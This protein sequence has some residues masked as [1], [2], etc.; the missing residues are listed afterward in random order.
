MCYQ[1]SFDEAINDA[2]AASESLRGRSETT[3]QCM[4][5]SARVSSSGSI[6]DFLAE[7]ELE[8]KSISDFMLCLED[9][10][11]AASHHTKCNM[12]IFLYPKPAAAISKKVNRS[13]SNDTRIVIEKKEPC[14]NHSDASKMSAESRE[15]LRRSKNREYQR[16]FRE[17]KIRLELERM[18]KTRSISF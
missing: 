15:E 11:I 2:L 13:A 1:S 9:Q 5:F 10:S 12:D 6:D 3:E 17:K 18:S 16:R 7:Y 14:T 4:L 8:T